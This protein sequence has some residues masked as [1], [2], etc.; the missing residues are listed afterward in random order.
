MVYAANGG[1]L[2]NGTAVVARFAYPT[3]G[4]VGGLRGVDDSPRLSR[5]RNPSRQRGPG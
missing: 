4:R 1:L 5:R 2:V 3:R